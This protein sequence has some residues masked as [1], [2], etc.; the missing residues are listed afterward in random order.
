MLLNRFCVVIRKKTVSD[1]RA[2]PAT[3]GLWAPL[4]AASQHYVSSSRGIRSKPVPR[5]TESFPSHHQRASDPGRFVGQRMMTTL[6]GRRSPDPCLAG[7]GSCSG[8]ADNTTLH[9]LEQ[10]ADLAIA[11][12]EDR[13]P[14]NR[15]LMD[16]SLLSIGGKYKRPSKHNQWKSPTGTFHGPLL[17]DGLLSEKGR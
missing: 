4:S 2:I 7:C 13:T 17:D 14:I 15:R 10:M 8:E 12:G 16:N 9:R 5:A 3:L 11:A 6:S 1:A